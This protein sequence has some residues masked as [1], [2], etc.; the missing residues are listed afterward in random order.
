MSKQRQ[1]A[2]CIFAIQL[3]THRLQQLLC[4]DRIFIIIAR[5]LLC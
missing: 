3:D 2:P 1:T 4:R 5:S